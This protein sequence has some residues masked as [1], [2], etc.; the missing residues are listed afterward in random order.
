M[1]RTKEYQLRGKM[2]KE[3]LNAIPSLEM[4]IKTC[5]STPDFMK[6][7]RRLS[8]HSLGRAAPIIMMIDKATGKTDAEAKEFFEFVR[9][10]IWWP[11]VFNILHETERHDC[12]APTRIKGEKR[13]N[14]CPDTQ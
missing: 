3:V 10:H 2:S 4:A 8:G 1:T 12:I 14:P 13:S 6:E 7:Y 5:L 9:E 11:V